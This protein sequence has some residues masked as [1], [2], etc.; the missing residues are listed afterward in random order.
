LVDN[1]GGGYIGESIY[2]R[3]DSSLRPTLK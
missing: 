1:V 3:G 2:I